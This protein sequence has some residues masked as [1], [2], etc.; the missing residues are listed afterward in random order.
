ME[1]HFPS[2][3]TLKIFGRNG[4]QHNLPQSAKPTHLSFLTLFLR[5]QVNKCCFGSE[6]AALR[7]FYRLAKAEA[8]RGQAL[9]WCQMQLGWIF[10]VLG[11]QRAG[12][13]PEAVPRTPH[14]GPPTCPPAHGV[15]AASLVQ[16]QACRSQGGSGSQTHAQPTSSHRW[17]YNGD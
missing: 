8:P 2:L 1:E 11:K 14:P 7:S 15:L 3:R 12:A 10:E 9:C 13:K 5:N 16:G 6:E 17:R 4:T